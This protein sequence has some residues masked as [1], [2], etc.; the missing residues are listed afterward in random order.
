MLSK[1]FRHQYNVRL[2]IDPKINRWLTSEARRA[3]AFARGYHRGSY[4]AKERTGRVQV[5]EHRPYQLGSVGT[6]A[7][8]NS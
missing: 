8:P 5:R 6:K 3:V 4:P 1:P 2:A 7:R